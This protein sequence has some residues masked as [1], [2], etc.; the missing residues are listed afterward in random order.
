V[1]PDV[2]QVREQYYAHGETLRWRTKAQALRFFDGLDLV[3]PGLVQMHKWRPDPVDIGRM[4]ADKDI[5]MYGGS[6]SC[7]EPV[8]RSRPH[9]GVVPRVT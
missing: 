2:A 8:R 1:Y 3:E 6:R 4:P 7:R 9:T 5:A